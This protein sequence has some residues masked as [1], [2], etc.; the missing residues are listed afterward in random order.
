MIL[1]ARSK[2]ATSNEFKRV[3]IWG[4]KSQA[5][6]LI[7]SNFNTLL[8]AMPELKSNF[9]ITN[10]GK[11]VPIQGADNSSMNNHGNAVVQGQDRNSVSNPSARVLPPR[12]NL[13]NSFQLSRDN[14]MPKRTTTP[15]TD[16][17]G[18]SADLPQTSHIK[19]RQMLHS[20]GLIMGSFKAGPPPML[21]TKMFS[22]GF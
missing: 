9:R 17:T 13:E 20:E 1:R 7:E 8:G 11:V 15:L 22:Q 4:S 6:R 5:E 18:P 14:Q 10:H 16:S 3:R 19:W 12:N 21:Q 2:L